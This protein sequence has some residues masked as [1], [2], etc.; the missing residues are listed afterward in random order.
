MAKR[1]LGAL[2]VLV[3]LCPRI[4]SAAVAQERHAARA[5]AVQHEL[6]TEYVRNPVEYRAL[7]KQT[8]EGHLGALALIATG[9]AP[10]ED[11]MP[12]H[13][14]ALVALT[15]IHASLY[16]EGSQTPRAR[17]SVWTDRNAFESASSATARVAEQ[18]RDAVERR[19]QVQIMN[20][21]AALG[22]SCETCHARFRVSRDR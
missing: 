1:G 11:Q 21:L 20:G 22:E 17:D 15:A 12:F 4:H 7:I 16:P 9:R 2:V 3:V 8:L 19:N 18:L 5:P 13:A 14:D 6:V 10:D